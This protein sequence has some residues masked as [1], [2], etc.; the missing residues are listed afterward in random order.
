M[1]FN[2]TAETRDVYFLPMGFC[3]VNNHWMCL[4]LP[5]AREIIAENDTRKEYEVMTW[6]TPGD[7]LTLV[8]MVRFRGVCRVEV[9]NRWVGV[10]ERLR[11]SLA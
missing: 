1:L 5:C 10:Q 2:E 4:C 6:V 8:P 7:E 3:H 9:S 11:I